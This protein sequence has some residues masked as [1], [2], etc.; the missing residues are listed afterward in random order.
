M[1]DYVYIWMLLFWVIR[2]ATSRKLRNIAAEPGNFL[3]KRYLYCSSHCFVSTVTVPY[4]HV[5]LYIL[6]ITPSLFGSIWIRFWYSEILS[7]H[8][9]HRF[10][11]IF[12]PRNVGLEP[13]IMQ[14]SAIFAEIWWIIDFPV[15]AALICIQ[16]IC[17]TFFLI[18]NMDFR[19]LHLFC[20][21]RNVD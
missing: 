12:D 4:N 7:G 1:W 20:R 9:R 16:I 2:L 8:L 18:V 3:G 6:L 10:I 14:L 11:M 21:S 17:G 5:L 15:M 13:L 19:F